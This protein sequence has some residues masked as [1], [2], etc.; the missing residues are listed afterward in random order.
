MSEKTKD[1]GLKSSVQ[2]LGAY[3]SGIAMPNLG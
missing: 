3:V 1:S 2:K